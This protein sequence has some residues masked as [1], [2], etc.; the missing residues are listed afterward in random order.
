MGFKEEYAKFTQPSNAREA[1]VYKAVTSLPRD[2]IIA[3][4]KPVT[5]DMPNGVKRTYKV[6]PD[7]FSVDGVRVPMSGQTAQRVADHFGL[8]LPTTD[9]SKAIYQNSVKINSKPLS[10]SGT[11]VSGK[12]YTGDQVVDT[13]VGYAPFAINYNDKINKQ[14]EEKG[15]KPGSIV[16]GFAKDIVAP[17]PGTSTLGLHGFYDENGRPIQG[18]SGQTPHDTSIH[19]EYGSFL[20]G[21]SPEYVDQYPDGKTVT[22]SLKNTR[23]TPAPKDKPVASTTTPV[24]TTPQNKEYTPPEPKPGYSL[25]LDRVNKFFGDLGSK[26]NF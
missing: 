22:K 13:G 15:I 7:Y 18:G 11:T 4:M 26:F 6:M 8:S 19:S 10:G 21:I 24:I 16:S 1:F 9:I 14:L 5:V 20:R 3:S 2:Q 17:P 23:Y 25:L 12:H